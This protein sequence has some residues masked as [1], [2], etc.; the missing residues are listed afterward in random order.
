MLHHAAFW[1]NALPSEVAW[2]LSGQCRR[3]LN[4]RILREY[5]NPDPHS[6]DLH[7]SAAYSFVSGSWR[8]AYPL[9]WLYLK[10]D[11][12]NRCGS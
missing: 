3:V 4:L 6:V 9:P 7:S 1:F 10:R 5:G 2:G 8:A 11:R 12:T